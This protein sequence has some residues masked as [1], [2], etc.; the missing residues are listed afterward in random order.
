MNKKEIKQTLDSISLNNYIEE[1]LI[2][3]EP[4]KINEK[5]KSKIK[6]GNMV[7]NNVKKFN[8]LQK[9]MFKLFFGVKIEDF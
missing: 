9:M 2:Y 7:I 3:I 4:R 8:L 6:L 1:P 5:Y